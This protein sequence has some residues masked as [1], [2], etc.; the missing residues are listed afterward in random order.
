MA[1]PRNDV[2]AFLLRR[3]PFFFTFFPAEGFPAASF[4]PTR[5]VRA[6][7]PEAPGNSSHASAVSSD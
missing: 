5:Q 7:P 4:L 1:A 3:R 2:S 6:L